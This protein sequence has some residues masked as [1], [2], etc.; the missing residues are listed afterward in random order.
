MM[1]RLGLRMGLPVNSSTLN[2]DRTSLVHTRT[3]TSLIETGSF[4]DFFHSDDYTIT[5]LV[6]N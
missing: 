3:S 4:K 2:F 5:S 1:A 6:T